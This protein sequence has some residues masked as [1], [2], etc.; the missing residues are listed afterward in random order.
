VV[1]VRAVDVLKTVSL[2]IADP[3]LLARAT[4]T[5]LHIRESVPVLRH[6]V[7]AVERMTPV[8]HLM[9]VLLHV[10]ILSVTDRIVQRFA[11]HPARMVPDRF[12]RQTLAASHVAP[13]V[14]LSAFVA[15]GASVVANKTVVTSL[16]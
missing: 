4:S 14:L 9:D 7:A 1:A 3:R 12:V 2:I 11:V 16:S 8:V 15:T 13:Q 10:T 6:N 5:C